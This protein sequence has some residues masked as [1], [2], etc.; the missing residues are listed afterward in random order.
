MAHGARATV[1][2]PRAHGLGCVGDDH[3]AVRLGEIHDGVI[4]RGHAVEVDRDDQARAKPCLHR[5]RMGFLKTGGG[6]VEAGRVDIHPDRRRTAQQCGLEGRG[7]SHRRCQHG[8]PR[9]DLLGE[10]HQHQRIRSVGAGNHVAGAREGRD[11]LLEQADFRPQDVLA[12]VQ[13]ARDCGIDL[14]PQS[15]LLGFEVDEWDAAH[16]ASSNRPSAVKR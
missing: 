15:R 7:K 10:M 6:Q 14:V 2:A 1:A 16:A 5:A 12:V 8:V 13:Y 11:L 3:Q 9:A 4:V